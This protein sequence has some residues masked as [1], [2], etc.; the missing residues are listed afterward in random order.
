MKKLLYAALLLFSVQSFA[1]KQQ[2]VNPTSKIYPV[3]E[4]GQ[5]GSSITILHGRTVKMPDLVG[6][7]GQVLTKNADG[8]IG[9]TTPAASG[10]SLPDVVSPGTA[11]SAT[12]TLQ[13]TY[14]SKG[15][16]TSVV[17]QPVSLGF[18][19]L[20]ANKVVSTLPNSDDYI[21]TSRAVLA[22]QYG[23][24]QTAIN[25]T[26]AKVDS[27]AG[28]LR[29][30]TSDTVRKAFS[31]AIIPL[32]PGDFIIKPDSSL[33]INRA[34]FTGTGSASTVPVVTTSNNTNG[35]SLTVNWTSVGALFYNVYRYTAGSNTPTLV[36]PNTTALTFNDT[37]LSPNTQYSYSVMPIFGSSV[38]T[39]T[40]AATFLPFL[41]IDFAQTGTDSRNE[42]LWYYNP[43]GD[44]QPPSN[45]SVQLVTNNSANQTGYLLR[46]SGAGFPAGT[47]RV[48]IQGL[49]PSATVVFGNAQASSGNNIFL[50]TLTESSTNALA[51]Q[52]TSG[53]GPNTSVSISG[54]IMEKAN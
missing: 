47:Y 41:S 8:S 33:A 5:D 40:P 45:G 37:G 24:L 15:Q 25:R 35:I 6:T 21:S 18:P 4:F 12:K 1:Q 36:L 17:E 46:S 31:T 44:S 22:G 11:G 23:V 7:T 27:I 26:Q 34:S 30:N 43:N 28:I 51:V 10:G 14:N 39:T 38:T 9:L 19:A 20:N 32:F 53:T 54:F 2:T 42:D 49:T 48:T 13:V 50:V 3:N 16:I 52:I 29:K